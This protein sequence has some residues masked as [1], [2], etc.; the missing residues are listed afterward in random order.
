[1]ISGLYRTHDE[2]LGLCARVDRSAGDA[3]PLLKREIYEALGGQ[4][5]FDRLPTEEEFA[6]PENWGPAG[7]GTIQ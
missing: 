7:K 3:A 4:P 5:K 1:M 2:F 6:A